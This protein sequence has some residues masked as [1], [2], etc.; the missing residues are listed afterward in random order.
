M[1]EAVTFLSELRG[2]LGNAPDTP[3]LYQ[4][5]CGVMI[6]GVAG[7]MLNK[8]LPALLVIVATIA[9]ALMAATFGLIEFSALYAVIEC[10]DQRL[11]EFVVAPGFPA[12]S[13][14][15]VALAHVRFA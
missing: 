4:F 9:S 3:F 11:S 10:F 8:C 14:A 15:G 2:T 13:A 12:G 7:V 5:M 1:V 6:G